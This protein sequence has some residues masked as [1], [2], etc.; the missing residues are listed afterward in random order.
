MLNTIGKRCKNTLAKIY[1]TNFLL[2]CQ[3]IISL[4]QK[5]FQD[6]WRNYFS[7]KLNNNLAGNCMVGNGNPNVWYNK[8]D[9]STKREYFELEN[10]KV[11]KECE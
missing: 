6:R 1:L 9:Q 8:F 10:Y 2:N 7:I 5:D 3:K 4:K 11:K